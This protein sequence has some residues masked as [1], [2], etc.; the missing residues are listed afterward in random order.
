M[1]VV[2]VAEREQVDALAEI[3]AVARLQRPWSM[4]RSRRMRSSTWFSNSGSLLLAG[5]SPGSSGALPGYY[6]RSP[7]TRRQGEVRNYAHIPEML[8]QV[9]NHVSSVSSIAGL[10]SHQIL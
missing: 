6:A 4:I 3:V 1:L 5:E 8:F 10:L 7:A 9:L 2:A